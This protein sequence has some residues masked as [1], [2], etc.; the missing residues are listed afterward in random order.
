MS[1]VRRK[2]MP[3]GKKTNS[4]NQNGGLE[5]QNVKLGVYTVPTVSVNMLIRIMK[6]GSR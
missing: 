1:E 3:S 6:V 5:V 2:V 4:E